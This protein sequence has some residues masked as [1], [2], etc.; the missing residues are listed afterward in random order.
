MNNIAKT[1]PE[2]SIYLGPIDK[3]DNLTNPFKLTSSDFK[4][5]IFCFKNIEL[6]ED[7]LKY[8]LE[9]DKLVY[10]DKEYKNSDILTSL[11]CETTEYFYK[12]ISSPI[13]IDFI[14]LMAEADMTTLL[15]KEVN[16]GHH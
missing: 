15:K 4:D 7:L 1:C 8:E 6:N 14:K 9:F 2:Y 13:L 16:Y 3:D 12:N 5:T 10:K 11:G